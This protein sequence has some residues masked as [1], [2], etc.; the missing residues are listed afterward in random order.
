MSHLTFH[1]DEALGAL[2]ES[3]RLF[4]FALT[5]GV[6]IIAA[7]LCRQFVRG[8]RTTATGVPESD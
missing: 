3:L 1:P 2:F 7:I 8:W 6:P 5:Q 4:V